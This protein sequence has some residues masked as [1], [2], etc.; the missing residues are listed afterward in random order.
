M[1]NKPSKSNTAVI[2][3]LDSLKD[4]A[5]KYEDRI[6]IQ[7]EEEKKKDDSFVK[8]Y[9]KKN[10]KISIQEEIARTLQQAKLKEEEKRKLEAEKLKNK[11]ELENIN[12]ATVDFITGEFDEMMR[13]ADSDGDG[14]IDYGEFVKMMSP[15][16]SP[17]RGL[18]DYFEKLASAS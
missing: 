9:L 11:R 17:V 1:D 6:N 2:A 3:S 18:I 16:K 14:Q 13:V 15:L 8:E 7:C 5:S 12:R 10:K 4:F